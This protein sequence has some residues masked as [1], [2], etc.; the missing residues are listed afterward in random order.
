MN[1]IL[2]KVLVT[3]SCQAVRAPL[4]ISVEVKC[5][6]LGAPLLVTHPKL[7]LFSRLVSKS[8]DR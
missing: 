6:P 7:V 8:G 2:K 3:H 1:I 4:K 5:L